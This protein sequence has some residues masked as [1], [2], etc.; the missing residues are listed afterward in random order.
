MCCV[1]DLVSFDYL[2]LVLRFGIDKRLLLLEDAYKLL[3]RF[4]NSDIY[5]KLFLESFLK[6][7]G[8]SPNFL[9]LLLFGAML[10][11]L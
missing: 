8:L 1:T 5:Y 3:L 6:C 10:L 2:G 4:V 7:E 11:D 9:C